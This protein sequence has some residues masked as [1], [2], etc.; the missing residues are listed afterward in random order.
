MGKERYGGEKSYV[1]MLLTETK[2][3]KEEAKS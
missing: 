2:K 1:I 3:V